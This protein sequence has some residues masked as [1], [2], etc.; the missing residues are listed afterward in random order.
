[1]ST[2]NYRFAIL[3]AF[4]CGV[5]L[6]CGCGGT[7]ARYAIEGNVTL[8]GKPLQKGQISFVPLAGTK[9]PTAGAEIVDGKFSIPNEKGTFLGK[10]RVEVTA[11]RPTDKTMP[12]PMTGQPAKI[13]EQF[14]PD[15]YNKT[16]VLQ[17]EV[18]DD[19]HNNFEFPV[20]SK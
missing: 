8:D 1:M 19:G 15:K 3:P 20:T 14:I 16:S 2:T 9:G 12:D 17:A 18:K 6:L 10:F 4:A 5:L 7:K 11:S 13:Y